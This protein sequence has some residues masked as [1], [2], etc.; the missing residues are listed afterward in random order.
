MMMMMMMIMI[1]I[2]ETTKI[3]IATTTKIRKAMLQ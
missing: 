3:T 1:R 2:M